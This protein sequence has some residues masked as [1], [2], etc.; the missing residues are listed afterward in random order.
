MSISFG[1]YAWDYLKAW[2]EDAEP[3]ATTT[4]LGAAAV[5]A[6]ARHRMLR[7]VL[8]L[9]TNS[10][11]YSMPGTLLARYFGD[12]GTTVDRVSCFFAK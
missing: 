10:Y 11:V 7:W 3:S 5:S 1:S 4:T 2:D 12:N 8:T 6:S 9:K